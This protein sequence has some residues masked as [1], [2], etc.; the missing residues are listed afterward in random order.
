MTFPFT[1]QE[2]TRKPNPMRNLN[3]LARSSGRRVTLE[4][5]LNKLEDS[6]SW[7][8]TVRAH[9]KAM[10]KFNS[11]LI[12]KI[13]LVRLGD[14]IIDEDVQRALDEKHCANTIGGAKFNERYLQPVFAAK[15]SDGEYVSIDSQHSTTTVAGL[16]NAGLFDDIEDWRELEYPTL[17]V[18]TDDLS[19]ARKAFGIVNG[20]GKKRQSKYNELRN[21]VFCVRIDGNTEDE[22]DVIAERKVSIAESYDC[23]P[24]EVNSG[25]SKYPGTFTHISL[26][27]LATE[28]QLEAAFDWH[29]T[30]FHMDSVHASLF[31]IFRDIVRDFKSARME[32][33]PT[34]AVE[35]A[36]L[37]QGVFG[38][39]EQFGQSAMQAR[40]RWHNKRYGYE[41]NWS[42]D[43]YAVVL[44]QLYVKMGGKEQ[45]PL[46]LLDKYYDPKTNTGIADF[47]ADEILDMAVA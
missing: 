31:P 4:D 6:N 14:I 21:A 46:V 13:A 33:T 39:L 15:N 35:I 42:D 10:R 18:E 19:F 44:F 43:Q 20:K 3:P 36:G 23:Y 32:F 47:L 27:E 16:I 2:V 24:V 34:L 12:P 41:G 17:Y 11:G 5:R 30:Y 8:R 37:I 40:T 7:Q 26:F 45:I 1:Y 25:L 22:E 9:E 38:D 29:N 28:E